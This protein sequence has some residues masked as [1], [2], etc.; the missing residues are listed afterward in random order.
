MYTFSSSARSRDGVG[1]VR[2]PVI[3]AVGH[4]Y[5][6][7][8]TRSPSDAG[9]NRSASKGIR[10]PAP[11]CATITSTDSAAAMAKSRIEGERPNE[12]ALD[13]AHTDR[14][15]LAQTESHRGRDLSRAVA[16]ARFVRLRWMA[17]GMPAVVAAMSRR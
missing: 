1:A 3:R 5:V 14:Q 7:A 12:W 17:G 6:S 9:L 15:R 11:E 16:G 13:H 10:T 2:H 8:R 4:S